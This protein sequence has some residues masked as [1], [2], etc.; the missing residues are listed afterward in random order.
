MT[1]YLR[2]ISSTWIQA[3][4]V[5]P[6][7]NYNRWKDWNDKT[8]RGVSLYKEEEKYQG[9]RPIFTEL[10]HFKLLSTVMLKMQ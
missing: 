6:V 7:V 8:L 2:N 3:I 4:K 5:G 10:D 1:Y 9:F